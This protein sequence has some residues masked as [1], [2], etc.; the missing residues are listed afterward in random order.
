MRKKKQSKDFKLRP[1]GIDSV[2]FSTTMSQKPR[3]HES[4]MSDLQES[5][6]PPKFPEK[7]R[8]GSRIGNVGIH[9]LNQIRSGPDLPISTKELS[10]EYYTKI[11][12]EV[13]E[14]QIPKDLDWKGRIKY[15]R[16]NHT[17]GAPRRNKSESLNPHLNKMCVTE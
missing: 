15:Y 16:V 10:Q 8:K 12:P 4:A 17:S 11:I 2:D 3:F 6:H 7:L 14:T 9:Q 5:F 13:A 1:I